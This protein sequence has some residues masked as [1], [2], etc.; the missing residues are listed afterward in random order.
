MSNIIKSSKKDELEINLIS[1]NIVSRTSRD[2]NWARSAWDLYID[3]CAC[4]GE[5]VTTRERDALLSRENQRVCVYIYSKRLLL[6]LFQ[7][8]KSHLNST[9][10]KSS[11]RNS[12]RQ[13]SCPA[14]IYSFSQ[15]PSNWQHNSVL[16][17]SV[18]LQMDQ[19][20]VRKHPIPQTPRVMNIC[21]PV[22]CE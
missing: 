16:T 22:A 20:P 14:A 19:L 21:Y 15:L 18:R 4:Q 10:V 3:P 1:F 13:S 5:I 11:V 12:Q 8:A 2:R 7:G 6:C 17:V 9:L